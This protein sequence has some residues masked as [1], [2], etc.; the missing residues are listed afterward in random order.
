MIVYLYDI[1][2][3]LR[4][5]NRVKR[6]FYYNMNKQGISKYYWKTKSVLAVPNN[7]ERVVDRF[8]KEYSKSCVAY[9]IQCRQIEK[10]E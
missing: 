9:K 6:V 2:T 1:K 8:F 10:V 3:S 7:M 5:Y 4:N